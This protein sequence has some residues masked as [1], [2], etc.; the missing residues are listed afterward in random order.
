[1]NFSKRNLLLGVIGLI[2][3]IIM[4]RLI[5]FLLGLPALTLF[6]YGMTIVF[7]L[8]LLEVMRRLLFRIEQTQ[9]KDT[10]NLKTKDKEKIANLEPSKSIE[11]LGNNPNMEIQAELKRLKRQ[12]RLH[13]KQNNL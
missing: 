9:E 6:F 3:G 8:G 4:S 13:N 12:T 10:K 11:P 2:S 5:S 1:M 7:I